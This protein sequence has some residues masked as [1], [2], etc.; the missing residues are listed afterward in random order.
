MDGRKIRNFIKKQWVLIWLTAA[1]IALTAVISFAE[2]KNENNVIKRVFVPAAQTNELF[3]SNYLTVNGGARAA[4]FGKTEPAPY[5]VPLIIRNYHPSDPERVYDGTISYKLK[6]TITKPDGSAYTSVPNEIQ[7]TL[8]RGDTTLTLDSTHLSVQSEGSFNLTKTVT[9]SNPKG[10]DSHAWDITFTGIDL[11]S[12][13]CVTIEA[14]S[15][16]TGVSSISAVLR[17]ATNPEVRS[18]GWTG[19]F[20]DAQKKADNTAIPVD[21]Y[22]AFNYTISG[23]GK[24]LLYFSYDPAVFQVNPAFAAIDSTDEI[25]ES[26]TYKGGTAGRSEWKTIEIS[27]D[28]DTTG[29]NRYDFQIYKVNSSTVFSGYGDL[30]NYVELKQVDPQPS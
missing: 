30:E 16:T 24:K 23:T 2:Y 10:N 8:V 4:Y 26:N 15:Q 28:P 3:T 9:E 20:S 12:E 13:Y 27:A 14:L 1:V 6:A 21:T 17:V 18:M 7:I 29:N 5:T 19:M 25:E 22:D 11:D